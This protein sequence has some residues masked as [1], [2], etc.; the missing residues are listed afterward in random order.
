MNSTS[1]FFFFFVYTGGRNF[2]VIPM[3]L[4]DALLRSRPVW[5]RNCHWDWHDFFSELMLV[6]GCC[7]LPGSHLQ[8]Q[9]HLNILRDSKF[10]NQAWEKSNT[11]HLLNWLIN[12]NVAKSAG[13]KRLKQKLITYLHFSLQSHLLDACGQHSLR[14]SPSLWLYIC[15][16]SVLHLSFSFY[17]MCCEVYNIYK[18]AYNSYVCTG[19]A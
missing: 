6:S 12:R 18:S 4:S 5:S 15:Q 7:C 17:F 11:T 2:P 3:T 13:F 16:V 9:G 14:A 10:Q 8:Q 1:F 19:L